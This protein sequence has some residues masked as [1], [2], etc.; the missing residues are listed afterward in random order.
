MRKEAQLDPSKA[1]LV[2]MAQGPDRIGIVRDIA[3]AVDQ[4]GGSVATSKMTRLAGNFSVMMLISVDKGAV[5]HLLERLRGL[6]GLQ[7]MTRV[8]GPNTNGQKQEQIRL[9][10]TARM[11]LTGKDAPSVVNTVA[12]FLA[13][14][15]INIEDLSSDSSVP[16]EA[17]AAG[18]VVVVP[19]AQ[20]PSQGQSPILTL[21]ANLASEHAVDA[22]KLRNGLAELSKKLN[23][24]VEIWDE[25]SA[26]VVA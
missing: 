2:M 24:S 19:A 21:E 13:S 12:E 26:S 18:A 20:P 7:V 10:Y 11:R 16:T 1:H 5:N 8:T 22:A 23:V 17:Q 4:S 3:H 15:K 9:P 14:N 6:E 25:R